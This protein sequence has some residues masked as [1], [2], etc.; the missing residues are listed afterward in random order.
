MC[1]IYFYPRRH[2]T[3]K[4]HHC[5]C[6]A[7]N[8]EDHIYRAFT[9]KYNA[10]PEEQDPD[11]Y[12]AAFEIRHDHCITW[13][14]RG[15]FHMAI[16]RHE[17]CCHQGDQIAPKLSLSILRGCRQMYEEANFL[18]WTTNTFSF[19]DHH[20]F[21]DWVRQLKISQKRKL[22]AIHIDHTFSDLEWFCLTFV[23]PTLAKMLPSLRT[24]HVTLE[25]I[26]HG[27]SCRHPWHPT[28]PSRVKKHLSD[29]KRLPLK[30]VTV[31]FT[32][33]CE[34]EHRCADP[35]TIERKIK[36]AE[37]IRSMLLRSK[38]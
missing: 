38:K 1:P 7:V 20:S 16:K 29:L 2:H 35:D 12:R 10:I 22:A 18:L 33:G 15:S 19:T 8:S 23:S 21:K 5:V 30:H 34:Q 14:P 3:T 25:N 9:A 32:D 26:Y 4:F 13:R 27:P 28:K 31:S 11:C 24:L 37:E 36:I 17:W 6:T